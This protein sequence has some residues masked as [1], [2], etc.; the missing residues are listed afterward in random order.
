MPT[1]SYEALN[2]AGKPQK[3][4]IEAKTADEAVQR[5][6]SQGFFPTSVR[7]QKIKGGGGGGAAARVKAK[8]KKKGLSIG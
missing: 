5:I 7:E 4:S 3:G 1:Y 8:K 2:A 6:K